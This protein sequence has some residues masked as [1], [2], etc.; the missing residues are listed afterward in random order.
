MRNGT[1][2]RQKLGP[3]WLVRHA[4]CYLVD[5]RRRQPRRCV[6]GAMAEEV[7]RREARGRAPR[8]GWT[9]RGGQSASEG[10]M[11]TPSKAWTPPDIAPWQLWQNLG[12]R[13]PI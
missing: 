10:I 1:V 3:S 2:R 8:W 12:G 7:D 6:D 11:K 9:G 4:V 5:G 13:C